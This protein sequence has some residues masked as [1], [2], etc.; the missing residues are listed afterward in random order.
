M[1]HQKEQITICQQRR[2]ALFVLSLGINL[3][4]SVTKNATQHE[5]EMTTKKTTFVTVLAGET[6][7][8]MCWL[9]LFG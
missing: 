6:D 5:S 9:S 4:V 3:H 1:A 8:G 2:A 7:T